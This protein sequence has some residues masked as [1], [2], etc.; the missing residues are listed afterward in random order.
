VSSADVPNYR[1]NPELL[2]DVPGPVFNE[3]LVLRIN[4]AQTDQKYKISDDRK[5]FIE[6]ER[7]KSKKWS[8][9][10]LG[11]KFDQVIR[12]YEINK[13]YGQ[14]PVPDEKERGLIAEYR[15]GKITRDDLYDIYKKNGRTAYDDK[16]L[17][18]SFD[19]FINTGTGIKM[20]VSADPGAIPKVQ[21]ELADVLAK[22]G[23]T[24]SGISGGAL[25]DN[26]IFLIVVIVVLIL[27]LMLVSSKPT[28]QTYPKKPAC[29]VWMS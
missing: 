24:G 16:K 23:I 8:E 14:V 9:D 17:K 27:I 22:R 15:E 3:R 7:E 19:R 10:Q 28:Y 4:N 29:S 13:G 5:L 2:K 6:G 21:K 12:E 18:E 25:P 20:S 11:A 1:K 26:Y